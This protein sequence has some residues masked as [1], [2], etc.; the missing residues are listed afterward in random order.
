MNQRR[1]SRG[2]HSGAA[3]DVQCSLVDFASS[4]SMI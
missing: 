1:L 4:S 3:E 2:S